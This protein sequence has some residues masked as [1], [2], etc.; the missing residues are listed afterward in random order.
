MKSLR[1]MIQHVRSHRDE[2]WALATLVETEGSTYRKPGARMLIDSQ[3]GTIG[4]LSGGCLEQE[5]AQ[6]AHAVLRGAP[7]LMLE[8]DTRRLYG[9][10]GQVRIFIEAVTPAADQGNFL[11]RLGEGLDRRQ[12][13]R[14]RTCYETASEPTGTTLLSPS[15]LLTECPGALIHCVQLPVRLLL[16]GSGPEIDPLRQLAATMGWVAAHFEHTSDTPDDL[17]LDA[18]TAILVMMHHF[19]RDLTVLHRLLPLQPAYVGLLG[20]RRR[21]WQLLQELLAQP[22]FDPGCLGSLYAPAGLDLGSEAPEEIALSI[23]SE[24]SAVLADRQGGHLRDR[25]TAIHLSSDAKAVTAQVA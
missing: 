6:H 11:T 23:I 16:F 12:L 13:C 22:D 21:S 24:V 17:E 20:P 1:Q 5:I 2:P 25:A 19:G 9:C 14:L 4:V 8:F 10:N 15:E 3:G 18:Q 7:P